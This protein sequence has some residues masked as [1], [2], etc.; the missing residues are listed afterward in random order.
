MM[1]FIEEELPIGSAWE[2]QS[3]GTQRE[4]GGPARIGGHE[5]SEG[6]NHAGTSQPGSSFQVHEPPGQ[7]NRSYSPAPRCPPFGAHIE[8]SEA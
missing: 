4:S 1:Y 2:M 8:H 3:L 6:R 7:A 5:V